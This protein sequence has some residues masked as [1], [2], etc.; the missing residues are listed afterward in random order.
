MWVSSIFQVLQGRKT[1]IVAI[2][3]IIVAG[4]HVQGYIGD[5]MFNTIEGI[6]GALGLA[7]LRHG[8]AKS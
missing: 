2:V 8:V 5:A 3:G 6:L 4:L 1:Y 7:A